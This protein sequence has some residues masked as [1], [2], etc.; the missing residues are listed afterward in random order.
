MTSLAFIFGMTPMFVAVGA[1]ANARHSVA[2]GV[3]GGMVGATTLALFFVPMFYYLVET[4]GEK[5]SA[6][7]DTKAGKAKAMQK[8]GGAPAGAHQQRRAGE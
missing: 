3:I 2:T 8:S 5:L 6:I 4:A 1:G 7:K